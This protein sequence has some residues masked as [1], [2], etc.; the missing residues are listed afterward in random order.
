MENEIDWLEDF[1]F[2][3]VVRQISMTSC[4]RLRLY[5]SCISPLMVLLNLM[6]K[7]LEKHY[8]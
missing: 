8:R 1:I 3:S 2:I 5:F 7:N 6:G 4:R